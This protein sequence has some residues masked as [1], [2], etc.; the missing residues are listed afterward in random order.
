MSLCA[1]LCDPT[2]AISVQAIAAPVQ[3][4]KAGS[5]N[6][7]EKL[8]GRK[9]YIRQLQKRTSLCVGWREI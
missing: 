3:T 7:L 2:G 9:A 5:V 8:E 6:T 1:Q 4:E